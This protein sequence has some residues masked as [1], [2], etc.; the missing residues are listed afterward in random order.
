MILWFFIYAVLHGYFGNYVYQLI[1]KREVEEGIHVVE[2]YFSLLPH[3]DREKRDV[4]SEKIGKRVRKK[5]PQK[6]IVNEKNV[7]D[8]L[9]ICPHSDVDTVVQWVGVTLI[10]F[11]YLFF[12]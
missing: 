6:L 12:R 11:I 3:M 8:Y 1:V 7:L 10:F 5:Y 9:K 2:R 4:Y